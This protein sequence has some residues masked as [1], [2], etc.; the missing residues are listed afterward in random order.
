MGGAS[1]YGWRN[2][3]K[4][5]PNPAEVTELKKVKDRILWFRDHKHETLPNRYKFLTEFDRNELRYWS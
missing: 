3:L 5:Q 2:V 1:Q 4:K